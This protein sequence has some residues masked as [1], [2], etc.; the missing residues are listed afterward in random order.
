MAELTVREEEKSF[1]LLSLLLSQKVSTLSFLKSNR[2]GGYGEQQ[3]YKTVGRFLEIAPR[4][5]Q[6]SFSLLFGMTNTEPNHQNLA[7][8]LMHAT[9]DMARR[10]QVTPLHYPPLKERQ[11]MENLRIILRLQAGTGRRTPTKNMALKKRQRLGMM[12][13]SP[14]RG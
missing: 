1:S 6:V 7:D 5:R 8:G 4:C 12:T 2:R 11:G 10:Q 3:S 9:V 13:T 14:H